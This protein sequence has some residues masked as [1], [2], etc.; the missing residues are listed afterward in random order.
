MLLSLHAAQVGPCLPW[1]HTYR[2]EL[3]VLQLDDVSDT[4]IHPLLLP[5]AAEGQQSG[6]RQEPAA[7][8][9]PC[10]TA[11]CPCLQPCAAS[12]RAPCPCP[13]LPCPHD[14][15]TPPIST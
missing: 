6:V 1:C 13:R 11:L 2:H 3:V 15:H 8:P 9:L 14:T 4:D 10:P 5:E 12:H 7:L